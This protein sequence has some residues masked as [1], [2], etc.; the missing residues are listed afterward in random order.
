MAKQRE[1]MTRFE[2]RVA[3][4]LEASEEPLTAEEIRK[5]LRLPAED[6]TEVRKI[7][8]AF[9]WL[10]ANRVIKHTSKIGA[11]KFGR[12][13]DPPKAKEPKAEKPAKPKKARKPKSEPPSPA[14]EVA[15]TQA[16]APAQE[17][18]VSA[19]R[20]AIFAKARELRTR[21]AGPLS[22]ALGISRGAVVRAFQRHPEVAAEIE[23]L[24][25]E[26]ETKGE[27]VAA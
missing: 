24:M 22:K 17:A 26:V 19:D 11:Y 12:W 2:E 1:E 20:E 3:K 9:R 23:A 5:A 7:R 21:H 6:P 27:E 18:E 10:K 13:P 8:N 14:P 16:E 25:S 4:A 15:E